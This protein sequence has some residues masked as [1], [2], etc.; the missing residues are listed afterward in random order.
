MT[1]IKKEKKERLKIYHFKNI[2]Q[3]HSIL[4]FKMIILG[5]GEIIKK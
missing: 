5:K 3:F 2:N 4:E 1:D